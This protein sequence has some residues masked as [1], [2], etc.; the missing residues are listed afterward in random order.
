MVEEELVTGD[1]RGDGDADVVSVEPT[2]HSLWWVRLLKQL[3]RRRTHLEGDV[4]RPLDARHHGFLS[5]HCTCNINF[6]TP[7]II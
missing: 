3:R 7:F 2:P 5:I 4:L 1:S 6:I